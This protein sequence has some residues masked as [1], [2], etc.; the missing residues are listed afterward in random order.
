MRNAGKAIFRGISP[1]KSSQCS[2]TRSMIA[3]ACAGVAR[4]LKMAMQFQTKNHLKSMRAGLTLPI[5]DPP[6]KGPK[7]SKRRNGSLKNVKSWWTIS[8]ERT[9]VSCR[10]VASSVELCSAS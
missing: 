3:V 5:K 6:C 8:G 4:E 7:V 9:L 2:S 1:I 10:C